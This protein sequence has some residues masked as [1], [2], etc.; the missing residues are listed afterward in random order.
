MTTVSC[1]D[2][3]TVL[4]IAAYLLAAGTCRRIFG[5]WA[6]LASRKRQPMAPDAPDSGE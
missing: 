5:G 4:L 1:R 2:F 3:A 6:R